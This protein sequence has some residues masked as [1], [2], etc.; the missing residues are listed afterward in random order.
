MSNDATDLVHQLLGEYI[1]EAKRVLADR[2]TQRELLR[3]LWL[4][5][6]LFILTTA[7]FIVAAMMGAVIPDVAWGMLPLAI[8]AIF[9][10]ARTARPKL[11]IGDPELVYWQLRKIYEIAS[12]Q[13]DYGHTM[14]RVYELGISMKLVEAEML[15]RRL[16]TIVDPK[17]IDFSKFGELATPPTDRDVRN[18]LSRPSDRDTP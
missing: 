7:C 6:F 1:G 13:L 17:S 16:E 12:R 18:S 10:M 8:V 4:T 2:H 14:D 15:L 5:I 11:L 9:M 3:P